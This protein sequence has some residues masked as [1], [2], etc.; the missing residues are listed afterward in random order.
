VQVDIKRVIAY[1][2]MSQ[3]G[4]MFVG[5]GLGAYGSGMFHLMTHAFFKA[6]LFM[7]AG[8]VIHAVAA[9]QDMRKMGG[10]RQLMP[11]TYWAFVIGAL[12]L[13]GIPPFAGF[14]SKDPI[15]SSA[16]AS[17]AYG[18]V[19][20]VVALVGAFLTGLYT[21]RM[22]FLVFWGE[23]SAFVREHF[24][25]LKNDVVGVSM[26][27]TVGVLAVLSVIGGWLQWVPFWDPVDTWLDTVAEPLV[28]PSNW[29][30]AVSSILAV[31]LGIAG[32]GVAWVFYGAKRRVVPRSA[33]WQ[34]LLEH[35]LYFDEAYDALFYR[36]AV[37]LARALS[38]WVEQPLIVRSTREVGEDTRELGGIL[39]RLQT[40][41]LRTYALAIASAAAVLVV[42][43][44]VVK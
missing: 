11:R 32:I 14:F 2:T 13:V 43:F 39:A 42:V 12:A 6:L 24:H 40:G 10:L 3:I 16:M 9:E 41:L 19:L 21:F 18:Y 25:A 15:V 7:A 38:R 29:Q 4:Y 37:W 30:E 36:P 33:F 1:S 44:V 17:G 35:K 26:G 20:W 28:S 27:A 22:L 8:I 34:R 5:V 31:G 23:P